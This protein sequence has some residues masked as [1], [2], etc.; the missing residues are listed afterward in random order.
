MCSLILPPSH[1]TDWT[2]NQETNNRIPHIRTNRPSRP[3]R[4]ATSYN[5]SVLS[6]CLQVVAHLSSSFTYNQQ[7]LYALLKS[8]FLG[9]FCINSN[10]IQRN[11][12]IVDNSGK[13]ENIIIDNTKLFF[14][15]CVWCHSL[16][17][18][19]AAFK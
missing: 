3:R 19:I 14:L 1:K 9:A 18:M 17:V 8:I 11:R 15:I 5:N 13:K 10:D 7:R 6:C 12:F 4:A 16:K 2:R